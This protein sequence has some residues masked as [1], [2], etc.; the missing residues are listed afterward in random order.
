MDT[1]RDE[2][3]TPE[4]EETAEVLPVA[5]RGLGLSSL[6]QSL[7]LFSNNGDMDFFKNPEYTTEENAE[8]LVR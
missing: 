4:G 3:L 1:Q 7:S 6:K 5:Q 8:L 2:F